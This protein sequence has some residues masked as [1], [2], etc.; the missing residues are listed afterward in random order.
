LGTVGPDLLPDLLF[1]EQ[2]DEPGAEQEAQ[3]EGG[4]PGQGRAHRDVTEDVEEEE[5]VAERDEEPVQ[6]GLLLSSGREGGDD[7]FRLHAPR[8][9]DQNEVTVP[10]AETQLTLYEPVE[11]LEGTASD[12]GTPGAV[13][14]VTVTALE[15][16]T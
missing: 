6:H 5:L 8:T 10:D 9:F 13:G 4:D 2:P 7:R 3:D 16:T 1:P 14:I 11:L 15:P 12:D